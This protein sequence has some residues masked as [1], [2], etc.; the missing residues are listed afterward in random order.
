MAVSLAPCPNRITKAGL[1]KSQCSVCPAWCRV[2]TQVPQRTTPQRGPLGCQHL[3]CALSS[4][5]AHTT[6]EEP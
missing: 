4:R 6:S 3:G 2:K 5:I 1:Q